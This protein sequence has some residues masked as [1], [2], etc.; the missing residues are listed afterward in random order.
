MISNKKEDN[1]DPRWMESH[2]ALDESIF[3]STELLSAPAVTK[4]PTKKKVAAATKKK[5]KGPAFVKKFKKAPEAPRRFKSAFIFF[6]IDKHRQIRE[7]L[8][9]EGTKEKVSFENRLIFLSS[10]TPKSLLTILS[11]NRVSP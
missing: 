9:R 2:H 11:I 5:A 3:E 6:S 4:P 7:S 8:S 1:R 10:F